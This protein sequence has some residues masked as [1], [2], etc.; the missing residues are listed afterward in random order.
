MAEPG[1]PIPAT[2]GATQVTDH[3]ADVGGAVDPHLI[4]TS[5]SI[6]Y[7]PTVA[8][9]NQTPA[10]LIPAATIAA[11]PLSVTL[12]DLKARTTYHYRLLANNS[13]GV[14]AGRDVTFTTARD[15]TPPKLT[16]VVKPQRLR[17]VRTRGVAYRLR[18]SERCAGPV[19]LVLS[20][21]AARKAALPV[22]LGKTTLTLPVRATSTQL[23]VRLSRRARRALAASPRRLRVTLK[24]G[25]SDDSH[26]RAV[27][28]R[29][30]T[31]R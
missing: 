24:L 25:L 20:R 18:C 16:L 2:G 23:R 4:D 31:V 13:A 30:I 14:T 26:N 11:A 19:Q 10:Q 28:N 15:V 29:T 7:G 5:A 27:A 12:Q 21:R 6:Q 22:L 3:T 17:T 1:P 9:E 8:Y